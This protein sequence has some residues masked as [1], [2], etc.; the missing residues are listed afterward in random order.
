M[1][2]LHQYGATPEKINI[3]PGS[4]ITL[5]APAFTDWMT[6]PKQNVFG[7]ATPYPTREVFAPVLLYT[8]DGTTLQDRSTGKPLGTL[9]QYP[10]A[11]NYLWEYT[12]HAKPHHCTYILR[13]WIIDPMPEAAALALVRATY[14]AETAAQ[15]FADFCEGW[16]V[17]KLD[18]MSA[19]TGE[20]SGPCFSE[21]LRVVFESTHQH[22]VYG[23]DHGAAIRAF[24]EAADAAIKALE[25]RLSE[26]LDK[27]S[28]ALETV[29][30]MGD[31]SY[32]LALG[33]YLPWRAAVGKVI[34]TEAPT[35]RRYVACRLVDA[36][37]QELQK[38]YSRA[39]SAV[40][41]AAGSAADHAGY[42]LAP[43]PTIR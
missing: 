35:L 38:G 39:V 4:Y 8:P 13:V 28:K 31:P 14:D 29:P 11:H 18:E 37:V 36:A 1:A 22:H 6:E 7:G 16:G 3:T 17:R 26:E 27:A 15:R 32:D 40:K 42:C 25:G 12:T 23:T 5:W 34:D 41:E 43:A 24:E 10:Y 9:T 33:A 2:A 19:G 30:P 20:E 21:R